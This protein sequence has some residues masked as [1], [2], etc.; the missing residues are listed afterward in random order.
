MFLVFYP[1]Q[2]HPPMS[3]EYTPSH[4]THPAWGME[5]MKAAYKAG[6][7]AASAAGKVA[8][9]AAR[10]TAEAAKTAAASAASAAKTTAR[11]AGAAA[12]AARKEMKQ[13]QMKQKAVGDVDLNRFIRDYKMVWDMGSHDL[14]E[15]E[16]KNMFKNGEPQGGVTY[17]SDVIGMLKEMMLDNEAD[18]YMTWTGSEESEEDV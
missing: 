9:S 11:V 5:T 17:D 7:K 1:F 14:A 8:A 13:K 6:S 18:M 4:L 16:V 10:K 2:P 15:Q 3:I 12:S